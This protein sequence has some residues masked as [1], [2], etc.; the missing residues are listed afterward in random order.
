VSEHKPS[1]RLYLLTAGVLLLG[2]LLVAVGTRNSRG[3]SA[4]ANDRLQNRGLDEVCPPPSGTPGLVERGAALQR[5][6][7]AGCHSDVHRE[8]GPSYAAIAER[9]H[10]RPVELSAAIGHPKPG[11]ADYPPGPAGPP[12][13]R[14][15]QSALVYWILNTG[16]HGDE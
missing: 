4:L 10:C 1:R 8:I 15:D 5:M 2:T 11:W 3:D 13:T 7:C 12:L 6:G 9:Y 14:D 16:G